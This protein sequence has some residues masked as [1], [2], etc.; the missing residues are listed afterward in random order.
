[1]KLSKS[2]QK[3]MEANPELALAVRRHPSSQSLTPAPKTVQAPKPKLRLV[4]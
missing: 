4:R 2:L 1:M 3:D